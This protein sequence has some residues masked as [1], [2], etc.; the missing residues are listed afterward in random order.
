MT[1]EPLIQ[2]AVWEKATLLVTNRTGKNVERGYV[3]TITARIG[4]SL[5]PKIRCPKSV[6]KGK[7][8]KNIS[9]TMKFP[10]GIL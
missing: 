6:S 9:L 8:G 5:N 3:K 10:S 1:I 2:L 4:F 7:V